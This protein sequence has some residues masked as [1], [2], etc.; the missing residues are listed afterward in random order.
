[1]FECVK[2]GVNIV[3]TLFFAKKDFSAAKNMST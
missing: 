3:H 2:L 1:M